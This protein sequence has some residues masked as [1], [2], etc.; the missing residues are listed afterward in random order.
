M[1]RRK[2]ARIV[3]KRVATLIGE[4]APVGLGHWGPVWTLATDPSGVFMDALKEWE[5]EE[6]PSTRRIVGESE[7]LAVAIDGPLRHG[8]ALDY[9]ASA[10]GVLRLGGGGGLARRRVTR[11]LGW[12]PHPPES[13]CRFRRIRRVLVHY[14]PPLEH[15]PGPDRTGH[16]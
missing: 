3:C 14:R 13:C 4:V 16:A 15:V 5:A 11:H 1:T 7:L 6:S 9:P 8:M 12:S 2:K 10:M